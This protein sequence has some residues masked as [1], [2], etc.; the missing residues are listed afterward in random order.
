MRMKPFLSEV[1]RRIQQ[2]FHDEVFQLQIVNDRN[3][4]VLRLHFCEGSGQKDILCRPSP[5]WYGS[6]YVHK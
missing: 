2:N 6:A 1:T 4:F 5:I 3:D